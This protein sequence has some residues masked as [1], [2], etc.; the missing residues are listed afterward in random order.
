MA[1]KETSARKK[2]FLP[3]EKYQIITVFVIPQIVSY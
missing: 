1:Q 3:G 2:G